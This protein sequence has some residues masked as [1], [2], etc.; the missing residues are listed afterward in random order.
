MRLS[1]STVLLLVCMIV[2]S[3][4]LANVANLLSTA[5]KYEPKY[6]NEKNK[7]TMTDKN[8]HLI[9]FLQ[10][11]DIHISVF[12]DQ[13]RTTEFKE[14]CEYI[15]KIFKPP[16]VLASG[17]LTDAKTHDGIGSNQ[18]QNEWVEYKNILSSLN[19]SQHTQ[20]LDIRGNHDNFNV[21]N[22]ESRENYFANFS[23]QGKAN[24]RSYMYQLE[25]NGD[26][27]SF[28]AVDAC[29][30]PG[31]RRPFNF[32]GMLDDVEIT[33]I[34]NIVKQIESSNSKY[35]IWFGHFPTSCILSQE[36]GGIRSLIGKH[37]HALAYLCGHLH[38]LGGAIPKM[39]TLQHAGFL[40]LELGDWKDNRMF[41]LLA[42]DHG[43]L[44][45]IDVKHRNW[46]VVLIT[47]PKHALY[48]MPQKENLEVITESTHIRLLIFSLAEIDV[49]KVQIN[50]EGWIEC[51]HVEGPLYVAPWNPKKY[52][53]GLHII[54]VYVSDGE[55]G[56]KIHSQPFSLDGTR[57]SFGLLP[58]L[59]LMT[60]ASTFFKFMFWCMIIFAVAPLLMMK[61]IHYRDIKKGKVKKRNGNTGYIR[62]WFRKIW[63]LS[64]VDRIFWPLVLYP[65]YLTV[66]PWSIGYI[67]E[68]R[69]GAIFAWGI[70][71]DGVFLP[72]SFTYAYG[73]I[74]LLTFQFPVTCILAHAVD[75][76]I[77][78]LI[79]KRKLSYV[80]KLTLHLPFLMVI[81]LQL[82]MA[83]NFWLAYGTLAF[84]IG[85]LRTWSIIIAIGLWIMML[86]LPED[87]TWDAAKVW[88]YTFKHMEEST[89]T[90][91]SN[92]FK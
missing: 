74:Q 17:D 41:R 78:A 48:I 72:G 89:L 2:L 26:V 68:D 44:S 76:R 83:Y 64:S 60:N 45:F 46:P 75:C 13:L 67:V 28:I 11:S 6:F 85:P 80:T 24:P 1:K 55:G 23:I 52:N 32:V 25:K 43:L 33:V 79:Q 63:I 66:G 15:V 65:I 27:Y 3:M 86:S 7:L 92:A 29:L 40:E 90:S 88:S 38:T 49:V 58:R 51:Q 34:N 81:I 30:Q 22:L 54:N 53:T 9:W 5:Q 37:D 21:L 57:L 18:I 16:V 8:E 77:R 56:R 87:C 4:F 20:W 14:F 12:R 59:V 69:V 39:Y 71:V 31:P 10:I 47:N 82:I 35:T 73:F 19:I 50:S 61:L 84:I 70:Y 91:C 42:I 36:P 62:S